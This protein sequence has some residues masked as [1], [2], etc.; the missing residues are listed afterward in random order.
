MT[1]QG[2]VAAIGALL[3]ALGVF[4][5]LARRHS[6]GA[7]IGVQ[8]ALL[9]GTVTL[10]GLSRLDSRPPQAF[11]GA[12]LAVVVALLAGGQ[13]LLGVALA[14]LLHRR[15]GDDSLDPGTG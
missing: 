3:L 9:A 6:L 15:L 5:A 14:V 1:A 11:G 10:A 2:E 4:G 8:V 13:A 12:A 7:L